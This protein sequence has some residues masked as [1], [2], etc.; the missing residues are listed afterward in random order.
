VYVNEHL[1]LGCFRLFSHV[2]NVPDVK[3]ALSCYATAQ[4]LDT[5]TDDTTTE[6]MDAKPILFGGTNR[7]NS[8]NVGTGLGKRMNSIDEIYIL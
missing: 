7:S 1:A 3:S 4:L 6:D 5:T 8:K 2:H